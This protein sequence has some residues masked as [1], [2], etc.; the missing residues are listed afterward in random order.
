MIRTRADNFYSIQYVNLNKIYVSKSV[1]TKNVKR[2][3]KI[4]YHFLLS[5]DAKEAL[6]QATITKPRKRTQAC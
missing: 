6:R 5:R 2:K 4:H 1:N 3:Q